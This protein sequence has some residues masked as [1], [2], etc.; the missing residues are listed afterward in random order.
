MNFL[1]YQ[2]ASA[3]GW[4]AAAGGSAAV[5]AAVVAAAFGAWAHLPGRF[6]TEE[7]RRD[8]TVTL[9]QL[10]ANALIGLEVQDGAAGESD[11]P[12]DPAPAESGSAPE[13]PPAEDPDIAPE[14]ADPDLPEQVGPTGDETGAGPERA[15]AAPGPQPDEGPLV[16]HESAPVQHAGA[17]GDAADQSGFT[18][19]SAAGESDQ[20]AM[21][22]P[23]PALPA[24]PGTGATPDTGGPVS[25]PPG[26]QD[27]AL[28]DLIRR[29]RTSPAAA[30]L[31]ALPRRDGETGAGL[32]LIGASGQDM[33][34]FSR[35][36]LSDVAD[37]IRQTRTLIDPRQCPA[38]D[39]VQKTKDYPVSRL[40]IRLDAAEVPSG[41]RLTGVVRGV[42]GKTVMLMMVDANG[43]VQD[44]DRFTTLNGNFARFEV[45][46]TRSGPQRD[47]AQLLLVLA[48][49]QPVGALKE[50]MGRLARDVLA[51]IES[52]EA[53][54]AAIAL[55]TFTVR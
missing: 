23:V 7:P 54:N 42:A 24:T 19:E 21:L 51:G 45:P 12:D 27:L 9:E 39:Y 20:L 31:V 5:H 13:T 11:G 22:Q 4:L 34:D 15:E 36:V 14:T 50:R 53:V 35:A 10:D 40:G 26:Q 33:R 41:G 48:T 29:I 37:Q 3:T 52:T 49:P 6:E 55:T 25:R 8:F 38:L 46:V 44:L 30:C 28:A 43:V 16:F 47:T 17:A 1:P 18:S 32:A 2:A